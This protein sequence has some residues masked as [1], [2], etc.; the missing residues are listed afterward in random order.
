M[1]KLKVFISWSGE[2]SRVVATKLDS[3][4]REVLQTVEPRFS[5]NTEKGKFWSNE[6]RKSLVTEF[7]IVCLTPENINENWIQFEAG[8][9]AKNEDGR[10]WTLL[11]GG[12][13]DSTVTPPLSL[14]QHTSTEKADFFKLL[15]SIN[16][17]CGQNALDNEVLKRVFD[18]NWEELADVF[19][20]T[21]LLPASSPSVPKRSTDDMIEEVLRNTRNIL[22][23][24]QNISSFEDLTE[25]ES[26]LEEDSEDI[27]DW[28]VIQKGTSVRH[29][30]FGDGIVIARLGEGKYSKVKVD[31]PKH[32]VKNLM[33][34][35]ARLKVL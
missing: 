30:S 19:A 11:L 15:E 1:E 32:G 21:A 25:L 28:T 4:L 29:V 5:P 8:A 16:N 34:K 33:L 3:W 13:Q 14:L 24:V 23:S 35:Y 26:L 22:S 12:L 7:G 18:K 9:L 17:A 20:K 10:A 6:I 2:R 27:G 31:F